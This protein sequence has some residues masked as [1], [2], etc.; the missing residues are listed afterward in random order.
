MVLA[1]I[2]IYAAVIA[3]ITRRAHTP[4]SDIIDQ[5]QSGFLSPCR[6]C[7][8]SLGSGGGDEAGGLMFAGAPAGGAHIL[9]FFAHLPCAQRKEV[10]ELFNLK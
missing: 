3:N 9:H 4:T 2:V 8:H 10:T 1:V 5:G 7:T 6:S